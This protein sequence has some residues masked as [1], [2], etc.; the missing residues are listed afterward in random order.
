M[1]VT[2]SNPHEMA[3]EPTPEL[4]YLRRWLKVAGGLGG[5]E[6]VAVSSYGT[7][8]AGIV[9]TTIPAF[10]PPVGS[11]GSVNVGATDSIPPLQVVFDS[12]GTLGPVSA[13]TAGAAGMD[14]TSAASSTCM[15]N[16][17]Y[18]TGQTCTVDVTFT[19]KF[20]VTRNGAIELNDTNGSVL[21][22]AY[23]QET[24]VGSQLGFSPGTQT[25]LGSSFSY[26][27]GIAV[28][29][30]G[31]VYVI[32]RINNLGNVHEI[33]AVNGRIPANPTIRTLVGGLDCPSGPAL[34]GA[35]NIYFVDSCYHTVNEIQA[36][37]GSIPS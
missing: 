1:Q 34:D 9:S 6:G 11:F 20:A 17:T 22:T 31:D 21:A 36:V 29:G 18:A 14:F 15:A 30:S 8:Y 26:A 32:D 35:G 23:L 4:P 13:L 5:V 10:I 27:Q 3:I 16:T 33:M 37:N 24:G 2:D 19:P 12:G 7:I 28:D 25:T